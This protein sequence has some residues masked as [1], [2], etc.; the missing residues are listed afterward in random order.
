MAATATAAAAAEPTAAAAAA[1][2]VPLP[3]A[4]T[5]AVPISLGTAASSTTASST[6]F[7]STP[8]RRKACG[9][10]ADKATSAN[11]MK[12][13]TDLPETSMDMDQLFYPAS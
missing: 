2:A 3:S 4:C 9:K 10:Q 11:N 5:D 7:F 8:R 13:D 12:S 1:H 6:A